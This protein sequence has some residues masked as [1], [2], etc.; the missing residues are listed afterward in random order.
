[1]SKTK[2]TKTKK[3]KYIFNDEYITNVINDVEEYGKE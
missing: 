1:M 3:V 2:T